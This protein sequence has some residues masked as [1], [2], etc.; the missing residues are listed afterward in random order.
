MRKT[1]VI[2]TL[3][4]LGM[5]STWVGAFDQERQAGEQPLD[6]LTTGP[7]QLMP[8]LMES[9][10]EAIL[11]RRGVDE[12]TVGDPYSFERK[13]TYLGVA[14]TE[15]V[16]LQA[17]CSTHPPDAGPCVE[18]GPAPVATSVDESDLAVIELP[19]RSTKNILC[20]TF[21]PFAN[22]E[23][24]NDTG[25][26]Q[27]ATMFL[28]PTVRIENEFLSDPSLIN[29]VTGLPFDGVLF[30]GTI[31]TFLQSRTLEPNE[32]DFQYHATTRSCTGGLVNVRSLRDTYGLTE[33]Q[34][35]RFFR[36]PMTLSFG[37]RG[38]VSM[39]TNGGY[40]VGIRLYGD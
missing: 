21:T 25:S 34:I 27:Y 23:W 40:F 22:W 16:S 3:L 11:K 7:G 10:E 15:S 35:R 8:G 33:S 20:F 37:V 17:D 1:F 13:K 30:D 12:D 29:P 28:R 32:Y 2:A 14:Q 5:G 9:D 39:V 31:S 18:V 4:V 19:G 26:Q 24:N 36:N 6:V 38:S